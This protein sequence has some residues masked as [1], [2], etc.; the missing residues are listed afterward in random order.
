M[1]GPNGEGRNLSKA[2]EAV[3]DGGCRENDSEKRRKMH[4]I[5]R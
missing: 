3:M 1:A 2:R 4:K 5:I